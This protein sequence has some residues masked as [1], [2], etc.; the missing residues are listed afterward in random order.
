MP[1][2]LLCGFSVF[3]SRILVSRPSGLAHPAGAMLYATLLRTESVGPDL[4]VPLKLFG[5]KNETKYS[6][7]SRRRVG[8]RQCRDAFHQR[9]R[10]K[11]DGQ[12]EVRGFAIELRH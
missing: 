12:P 10:A 9:P 3:E 7:T 2:V 1:G 11:I 4:V 6:Q 8:V 5:A